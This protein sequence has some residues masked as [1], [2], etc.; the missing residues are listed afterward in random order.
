MELVVCMV[1][2]RFSERE[3]DFLPRLWMWMLDAAVCFVLSLSP[4]HARNA[5]GGIL[6]NPLS[7]TI[8][9]RIWDI[10]SRSSLEYDHTPKSIIIKL[11]PDKSDK[12]RTLY[13]S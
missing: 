7:R 6:S 13:N 8:H 2:R 3:R 4:F 12:S 11:R 9:V 5:E 1:G 10:E